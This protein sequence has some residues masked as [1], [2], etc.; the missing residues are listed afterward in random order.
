MPFV[1]SMLSI[2][3]N[4][5]SSVPA[6]KAAMLHQWFTMPLEKTDKIRGAVIPWTDER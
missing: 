3:I 4:G 2:Q 5:K 1:K 6:V